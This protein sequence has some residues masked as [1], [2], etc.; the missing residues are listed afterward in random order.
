MICKGQIFLEIGPLGTVVLEES[1]HVDII[2]CSHCDKTHLGISSRS[3]DF[4]LKLDLEPME[5]EKLAAALINP[6][7]V[8]ERAR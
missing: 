7:P 2:L 4:A 1:L 5:A 6:E 3:K 8:K